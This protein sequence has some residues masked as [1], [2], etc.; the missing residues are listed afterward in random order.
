M[1]ALSSWDIRKSVSPGIFRKEEYQNKNEEKEVV[2]ETSEDQDDEEERIRKFRNGQLRN[3][4]ESLVFNPPI[5]LVR[6]ISK[7]R[8][9][10]I[11]FQNIQY[12]LAY[13]ENPAS[14]GRWAFQLVRLRFILKNV[15][16]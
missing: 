11:F 1:N 8:R 2:E 9:K 10:F 4:Q 16:Y 12:Q 14:W 13:P 5:S 7:G 6:G 15:L 3:R